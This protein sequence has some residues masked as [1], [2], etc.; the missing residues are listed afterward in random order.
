MRIRVC[1]L[2]GNGDPGGA[3]AKMALQ[4]LAL[5]VVSSGRSMPDHA[6][7]PRVEGMW[8][9]KEQPVEQRCS[10]QVLSFTKLCLRPMFRAPVP[11][12]TEPCDHGPCDGAGAAW[13]LQSGKSLHGT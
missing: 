8:A 11:C 2:V 6:V 4:R 7:W 3:M 9:A 10:E 1:L 12:W 13:T 5:G